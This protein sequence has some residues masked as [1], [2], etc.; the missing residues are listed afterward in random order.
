ML[1]SYKKC[2]TKLSQEVEGRWNLRG[3]EGSKFRY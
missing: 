1:Q 2:E 3:E